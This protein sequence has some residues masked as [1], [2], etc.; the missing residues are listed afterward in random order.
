MND[1][2]IRMLTVRIFATA[3]MLFLF[4]TK[5]CEQHM[6]LTCKSTN[7]SVN[8]LLILNSDTTVK[9]LSVRKWRSAFGIDTLFV[10]SILWLETAGTIISLV[11][12]SVTWYS[13]LLFDFSIMRSFFQY[14][15]LLC[16]LLFHLIIMI[17]KFPKLFI[18]WWLVFFVGRSPPS[19]PT[20]K[21]IVFRNCYVN[22]KYSFVDKKQN[23]TY[24]CSGS[25]SPNATILFFKCSSRIR[26][27]AKSVSSSAN[28]WSEI[29]LRFILYGNE[30]RW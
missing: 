8:K 9:L 21:G 15:L 29:P 2:T 5:I 30:D 12:K 3:D 23:W 25:N 16:L 17:I 13:I 18:K 27:S 26:L 7:K 10:N 19:S 4:R 6:L 22:K 28:L 24:I 11:F 1:S 14:I 20:T